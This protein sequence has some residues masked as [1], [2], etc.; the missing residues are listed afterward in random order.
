MS[1]DKSQYNASL[2]IDIGMNWS[3][4]MD[5]PRPH[6]LV[7][8]LCEKV[9]Q[10]KDETLTIVRIVDRLQYRIE[11]SG[12]P[13]GTTPMIS[14]KGLIALRSGPVTGEHP[15]KIVGE[16]PDGTRKDLYTAGVNFLGKDHGQNIIL[17]MGIGIDQDGLYWFDVFFDDELLTRIPLIVRPLTSQESEGPESP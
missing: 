17:D 10:E 11:G 7:A 2:F 4:K 9:L 6:L 14:I 3:Q 1:C 16:K 15:I 5:K 13:A 12:L 8:V